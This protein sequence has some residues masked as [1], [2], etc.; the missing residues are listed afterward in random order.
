VKL[1]DSGARREFGTGAVRD[2]A[3]EKGRFDLLPWRAITLGALQMERGA[4]KYAARNWERGIP[5]GEYKNSALRHL[6][7]HWLGFTDE[8]H[9]D[10]FVWNCLC[11]AETAERIRLGI[12]PKTLDNRPDIGR[13]T[14][15]EMGLVQS[16]RKPTKRKKKRHVR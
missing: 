11:Y 9:L 2:V 7:K 5:L 14:A 8:P 1:K 12:L 6:I 13:G 16:T 10:A 15:E 3:A 4:R